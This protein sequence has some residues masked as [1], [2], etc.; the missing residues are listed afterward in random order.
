[1]TWAHKTTG[2]FCWAVVNSWFL[3]NGHFLHPNP[4][5]DIWHVCCPQQIHIAS[6]SLFHTLPNFLKWICEYHTWW[7]SN[8]FCELFSC[9]QNLHSSL[10]KN[11][12]FPIYFM[13]VIIRAAEWFV[14]ILI[15][16]LIKMTI[17]SQQSC[18]IVSLRGPIR[19]LLFQ[20]SSFKPCMW[21]KNE[22][23]LMRKAL[24][25]ITAQ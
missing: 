15:K 24:R 7:Y 20:H 8:L 9:K 3:T 12:L 5:C 19:M 18:E 2:I 4:L 25:N 17:G 11:C 1:M 13:G 16:I 21:I 14:E 23:D 10:K 6:I 22:D